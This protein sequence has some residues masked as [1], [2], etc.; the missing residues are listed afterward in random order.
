MAEERFS[1]RVPAAA[2]YVGT[3]RIFG[4]A[5]ARQAGLSEDDVDDVKLAI[6]EACAAGV[7]EDGD[8]TIGVVGER[9]GAILAFEIVGEDIPPPLSDDLVATPES[10]RRSVG[11]DVIRSLFPD[12]AIL[13]E[14][15]RSGRIRFAVPI[16]G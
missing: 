12:A 14:G 15:D 7:R 3:A 1:L 8:G 4:G 13:S 9:D 6:S 16:D 5:I 10:F 2:A 11:Y